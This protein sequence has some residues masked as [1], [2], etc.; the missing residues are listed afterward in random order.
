MALI[1]GGVSVKLTVLGKLL[2][3]HNA[4]FITCYCH[5]KVTRY[6]TILLSLNCK[7]L[8]YFYIT[9]Y[10]TFTLLLHYFRQNKRKYGLEYEGNIQSISATDRLK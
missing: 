4:L 5:F 7:A 9:F 3:K 2:Q 1:K 6:I 10:I 8:H